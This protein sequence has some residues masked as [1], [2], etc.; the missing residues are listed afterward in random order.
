MFLNAT[1]SEIMDPN[2]RNKIRPN[3]PPEELEALSELI[4]LQKD[5]VSAI[6]PCDKGAGVIILDFD[7]YIRSCNEHLASKQ[8]QEDGSFKDYYCKVGE[9]MMEVAKHKIIQLIEEGFD[10]EIISKDEYSAMDPTNMGP[11]KFYE[12]FKVHKSHTPGVAPPE[13][14]IISASGSITENIALFVENQIKDL[15]NKHS[16]YLQD[17]PD[18]LRTIEDINENNYIPEGS[19]LVS[20]DVSALYTNIPQD[21]GIA[22]VREALLE[23]KNSDIPAEFII[24]LLEIIL[25]YNI[26]EFNSELFLQ[27]IG[28]AMGTR[29]A[30]SYANIFMARRIDDK[31]ATLATQLEDGKNPLLCLK[32][33][34]DDIFTIYSGSLENLHKFLEELNN[35]HPTIKFTMNHTTPFSSSPSSDNPVPTPSCA[36]CTGDSLPFLDT[37]CSI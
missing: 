3:L 20:I 9:D 22:A 24:R 30:V 26:F 19:M 2:N 35:I 23:K 21:E 15:A 10:N 31:I 33:F 25:K 37:S 5:K 28:T 17:T 7:E 1:K 14:P 29:P 18:F 12:L 36:C 4:K 16:T 34:L 8:K 13:R 32:R 6:K 11:A 27:L